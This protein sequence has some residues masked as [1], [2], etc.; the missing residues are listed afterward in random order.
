MGQEW[1]AVGQGR[2]GGSGVHR[3]HLSRGRSWGRSHGPGERP[4]RSRNSGRELGTERGQTSI[5]QPESW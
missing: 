4:S 1:R 3:S 5:R 2:A